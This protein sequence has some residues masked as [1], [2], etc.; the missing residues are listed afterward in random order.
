MV[1]FSEIQ[2]FPDFLELFSGNFRTICPH[3]ENFGFFGRME[4]ALGHFAKDCRCA[5]DLKFG[6]CGHMGHFEL[7][8]HSKQK[9]E[10]DSSRSSSRGHEN[11]QT[12]PGRGRR[13]ENSKEQR[14]LH[15]VTGDT[16]AENRGSSDD[17]YVFNV[18][19][20]DG[21]NTMELTIEDKLVNVAIDS[22]ASCNIMSEEMF[23][24]VT[25]DNVR[26]LE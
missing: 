14:D 2:Q 3:F 22:G 12:K 8:C 23:N 19:S 10:R 16:I 7:R 4:S 9:K 13:E 5:R 25:G 26:L 18:G 20:T 6:K 1:R 17:F 21:Q 24:F 15:N 11:S